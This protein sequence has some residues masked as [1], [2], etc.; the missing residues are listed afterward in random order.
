MGGVSSLIRLKV[1]F[2]AATARSGF[3]LFGNRGDLLV[4]EGLEQIFV[5]RGYKISRNGL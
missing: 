5:P 3:E 1:S 4:A 2:S